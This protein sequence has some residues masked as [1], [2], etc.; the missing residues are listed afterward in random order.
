MIPYFFAASHW[1]YAR[2]AFVYVRTL[3]RLPNTV[4]TQFLEGQHVVHLQDGFWN[5]IWTDMSIEST[6][7]KIGKGPSG[8]IGVTT[9]ERAVK[10]WANSHH[11]CTEVATELEEL[12]TEKELKQ[13]IHKE[14][15][16][17][18]MKSDSA[19]RLKI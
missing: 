19:D 9:N 2:D 6:Y 3:E 1:N 15:Y 18:R 5:G 12:R 17:G 8:M 10:I 14:E 7:M 13:K 4:L 16:A 11:L